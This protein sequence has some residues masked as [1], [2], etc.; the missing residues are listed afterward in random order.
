MAMLAATV[1]N[2]GAVMGPTSSRGGRRTE[3]HPRTS[4]RARRAIS[5]E[6]AAT[7]TEMMVAAVADGTGTAAQISGVPVAGKTGT[8]ETGVEG[9][10][11][12]SFIA[13]APADRPRVAIAVMLENQDGTGGRTAA[14]I[15]K[16]LMQALLARRPTP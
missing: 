3:G 7:L 5:A 11:T 9:S 13:F 6:T 8:A 2:G 14:P 12:T 16:E 4:R 15:A 1:A 10:N